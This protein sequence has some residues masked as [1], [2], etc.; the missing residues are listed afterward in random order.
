MD[1]DFFCFC[2]SVLVGIVTLWMAFF[3]I[4]DVV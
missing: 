2:V 4:Y 1:D 3:I